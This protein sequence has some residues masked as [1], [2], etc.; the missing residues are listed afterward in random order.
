MSNPSRKKPAK[1]P[2]GVDAEDMYTRSATIETP[3][4]IASLSGRLSESRILM[5]RSMMLLASVKG[6][7]SPSK[8]RL[9]ETSYPLAMFTIL[10]R[11]V[12]A[13]G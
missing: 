7:A 11:I 2:Y 10:I 3:N 1:I 9:A 12:N 8:A 13:G 4:P 6:D 5:E